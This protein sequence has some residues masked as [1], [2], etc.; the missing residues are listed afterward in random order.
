[1]RW[2]TLGL[3]ATV[4]VWGALPRPAEAIDLA[5]VLLNDVSQSMDE[6]EYALVKDGYRSAFADP[7]VIAALMGNTGGVAVAYVEFSGKDEVKKVLDWQVLTD[8]ASARAF[9]QAIAAAPRSS[10]GNTAL[11]AGL[12]AAARMLLE[13]DFGAARQVIDIA[14]DHP[15]D[16]GRC[17]PIRDAAV[18]AGITINALPIIDEQVIGTIDGRQ[19]YS[20]ARWGSESVV[21]FYR[22]TVVGGPGSFAVEARTYAVF[23]E[24]LKRKLLLEFIASPGKDLP[25]QSAALLRAT[26]AGDG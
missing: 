20:T 4:A 6:G 19:T 11:S 25:G 5:L 16:G 8:A 17:G 1:M 2:K 24:A 3:A 14:S 13:S 12:S 22:R 21:D 9:G 7:D 18:A 10:A 15:S 26:A 23:G